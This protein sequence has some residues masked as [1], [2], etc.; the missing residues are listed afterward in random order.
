FAEATGFE[1]APNT[2]AVV[3]DAKGAMARV[4]AGV[5]DGDD[6]WALAGLP[7]KLPRARY[8]LAKGPVAIAPD[9]AAFAWDLGSYQFTRYKKGKRKAADLQ[10]DPSPRVSEALEMAA[11]MRLVR[12]LV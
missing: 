1:G 10:L 5:R 8:A 6:P 11:A 7:L 12:D 3:P 2:F 4:L 9:K